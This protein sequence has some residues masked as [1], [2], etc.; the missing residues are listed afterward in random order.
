MFIIVNISKDHLLN[1]L[2]EES[3]DIIY[4]NI[5]LMK[6]K[7]HICGKENIK[8]ELCE[9]AE[10][11]LGKLNLFI[12]ELINE[13]WKQPE[14]ISLIIEKTD[15]D[16]LK[17][18]L[19]PFFANSL[20]ENILSS[21]CIENNLLYTLT[22]LIKSEINKLNNINEKDKFLENT[23]CG[24]ILE[25]LIKKNDIHEYL[26][27][28]TKSAIDNLE[29]KIILNKITFK[30]EEISILFNDEE[31]KKESDK[32]NFNEEVN[33]DNEDIVSEIIRNKEKNEKKQ[34]YFNQN[35]KNPIDG[36]TL[37]QLIEENK[38][39]KDILNYLRQKLSIFEKNAGNKDIF[40]TYKL[41]N[42]IDKF[43]RKDV[44]TPFYH[45]T[46]FIVINFLDTIIKNIL[47][48]IHLI[49]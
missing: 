13:L 15:I 22:L 20:F 37:K 16:D 38:N 2:K 17:N 30:M 29:T 40:A 26:N 10:K 32:L 18:H 3:K 48:N 21:N 8:I 43:Q 11:I 33:S 7:N 28:I 44:L 12:P 5:E 36:G 39:N 35:Y 27:V 34:K 25:E 42:Y 46:F 9:N 45:Q 41:F 23:P 47:N 24:I 6:K 31:R 14:I 19:A 4:K 1:Q 49:P